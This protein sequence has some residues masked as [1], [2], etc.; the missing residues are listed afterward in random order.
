MKDI[1]KITL[2]KTLRIIAAITLV[3]IVGC[4]ALY[5]IKLNKYEKTYEALSQET[6][7]S[8][9]EEQKF[10]INSEGNAVFGTDALLTANAGSVAATVPEQVT[11][12]TAGTYV[13]PAATT[14]ANLAT[15]PVT[16]TA[17]QVITPEQ[18][19]Q[20]WQSYLTAPWKNPN[21]VAM[22]TANPDIYSWI[23]VKGTVINYPILQNAIDDE[24][25]LNHNLDGKTGYPGCLY[26]QRV[27][28]KTFQ[29]FLTVVYGHNM[30][31]G[32]MFG[33]LKNYT[34][35]KYFDEHNEIYVETPTE[36]I[37]YDVICAGRTDDTNLFVKFRMTE[38]VG[39]K[40]LI[41][42]LATQKDTVYKPAM[43]D[44]IAENDKFI[45]L[46][47][48]RSIDKNGRYVVIAKRRILPPLPNAGQ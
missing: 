40:K 22:A 17:P 7:D 39:V 41:L 13:P 26:T 24:W 36:K 8:Q 6:L 25:Y 2:Y 46:S 45:A 16:V 11:N 38:A 15:A 19:L 23:S 10:I 12:L 47:T 4:V 30:K 34:N 31:N 18:A 27:N 29:D 1:D 9:M 42:S 37:I 43:V 20:I 33:G 14:V 44:N 3:L 28:T 35:K 32:T 48:C 21:L 5:N